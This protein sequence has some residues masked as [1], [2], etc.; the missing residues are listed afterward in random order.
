M[1]GPEAIH[2]THCPPA[3]NLS[4]PAVYTLAASPWT[5]GISIPTNPLTTLDTDNNCKR[6]SVRSRESKEVQKLGLLAGRE[7]V[8]VK[9]LQ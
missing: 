9:F 7:N 2:S 4:A 3:L 5:R 1:S 8:R 6:G